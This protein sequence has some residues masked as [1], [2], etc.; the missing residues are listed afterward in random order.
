MFKFSITAIQCYAFVALY[1]RACSCILFN[2]CPLKSR[3]FKEKTQNSKN[4][5]Q[6]S[7]TAQCQEV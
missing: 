7:Q 5:H 1:F 3:G 6:T 2:L 4:T